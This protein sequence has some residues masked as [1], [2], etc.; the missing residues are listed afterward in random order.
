MVP[1][2]GGTDDIVVTEAAVATPASYEPTVTAGG[3]TGAGTIE[4]TNGGSAPVAA[5]VEAGAGAAEVVAAGPQ[6]HTGTVEPPLPSAGAGGGAG[7]GAGAQELITDGTDTQPSTA[8]H[9]GSKGSLPE[10]GSGA[11]DVQQ[12]AHLHCARDV[13]LT[14]QSAAMLRDA[15]ADEVGSEAD[16]EATPS[17]AAH[18]VASVL[19]QGYLLGEK[20]VAKVLDLQG[21][22]RLVARLSPPPHCLPRSMTHVSLAPLLLL[23][24]LTDEDSRINKYISVVMETANL[25]IQQLDETFRIAERASAAAD[26]AASVASRVNKRVA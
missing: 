15:K 8:A 16:G 19:A 6:A 1:S 13:Q 14:T 21:A 7:A 25:R 24:L 23:L 12:A 18:A 9:K 17:A 10:C 20:G 3:D 22:A 11:F 5:G 4:V 2:G 26:V